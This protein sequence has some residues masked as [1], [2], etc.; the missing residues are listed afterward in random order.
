MQ[1]SCPRAARLVRRETYLPGWT[2]RVD[3]RP[4]R[5]QRFA[6][7]F[8]AVTVTAG[9]HRITFAY[10]PPYIGWGFAA[11]AAGCAWLLLA[12]A[13][14]RRKRREGRVACLMMMCFRLSGAPVRACR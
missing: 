2:A 1:L 10:S 3:G 11:F 14:G 12:G 6:G 9:T 5:V 7:L 8:Q 13:S 4:E